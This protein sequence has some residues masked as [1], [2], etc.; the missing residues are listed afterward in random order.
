MIAAGSAYDT[1]NLGRVEVTAH[2]AKRAAERMPGRDVVASLGRAVR[3]NTK[4]VCRE[5]RMKRNEMK[6]SNGDEFWR[7]PVCWTV[8]VVRRE[9]A[10]RCILITV[11][12][13]PA[14]YGD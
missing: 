2:A 1:P 4:A 12:N 7:D 5:L 14:K 3:L 13:S 10:E 8:F 11:F 6:R 9:T